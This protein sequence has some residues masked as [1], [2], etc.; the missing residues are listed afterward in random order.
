[1]SQNQNQIGIAHTFAVPLAILDLPDS[2]ALNA[3]LAT[4]FLAREQAQYAHQPPAPQ[5]F[6]GVFESVSGVIQ[7]QE[8]CIE[9][10]RGV[11]MAAVGRVVADL[12]GYGAEELANLGVLTQSRFHIM[13]RG[14]GSLAHNQPM[15]SWSAIYCVH[16]GDELPAH[17]ESGVLQV[18]DPRVP[19]NSY[20]DLA[21]ARWR[22][23]F[24]LGHLSVKPQAGQLVIFPAF[25]MREVSTYLGE[26]P[27][28][29]LG[30]GF[31]FA[32]RP[33]QSPTPAQAEM[34]TV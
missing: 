29:T 7:W 2:T 4:L 20:V 21:N 10:L 28:I 16:P 11:I 14:G 15:A 6:K 31:S 8:P 13:R 19:L 23:P 1:M 18:F 22:R 5:V 9:K 12:S 27:R 32:M 25:L 17:P 34:P 24:G 33:A 26:H 3:E 30:I